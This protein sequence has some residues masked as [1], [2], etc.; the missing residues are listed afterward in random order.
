MQIVAGHSLIAADRILVNNTTNRQ[1][2]EAQTSHTQYFLSLC[3]HKRFFP[4]DGGFG[5]AG[6]TSAG[7]LARMDNPALNTA[8]N[9]GVY[10]PTTH[11]GRNVDLCIGIN[12]PQILADMLANVR[13]IIRKFLLAG[14]IVLLSNG[15]PVTTFGTSGTNFDNWIAYHLALDVE[16]ARWPSGRVIRWDTFG[17]LVDPATVGTT[18]QPMTGVLIDDKHWNAYGAYLVGQAKNTA[19][20]AAGLLGAVDYSQTP[21]SNT[22]DAYNAST[23]PWGVIN[24]NPLMPTTATAGTMTSGG[25]GTVTGSVVTG[26]TARTVA[27]AGALNVTCT[28]GTDGNGDYQ[29]IAWTGTTGAGAPQLIFSQDPS[30]GTFG[31][32]DK[33]FVAAKFKVDAST[34]SNV[35]DIAVIAGFTSSGNPSAVQAKVQDIGLASG[36]ATGLGSKLFTFATAPVDKSKAGGTVSQTIARVLVDFP[37]SSATSGS[38]RIYMMSVRKWQWN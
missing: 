15:H 17:A 19:E 1:V 20:V 10:A 7:L 34:L 16:P 3:G 12:D 32:T 24:T 2:F 13:A 37:A 35:K 31:A 38:I 4:E 36:Y 28:Q 30:N 25:A 29:D 6:D 18:Y 11:P 21:T 26:Y 27:A 14:K 8:G 5:V 33:Y 22:A 9:F 23:N